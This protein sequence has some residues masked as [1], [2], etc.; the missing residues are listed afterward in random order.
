[1]MKHVVLA[2][3]LLMAAAQPSCAQPGAAG[4]IADLNAQ[5]KALS[6]TDPDK[7]LALAQQALARA[8]EAGDRRGEAEA[9]NYVAYGYR[10]QSLLDLARQNALESVRLYREAGDEW[11]QA[12]GYN[13]LG[14]IEAD[15]GKFP[16]ALE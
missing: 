3:L 2:A 14:L 1:M 16:E 11:G 9:L 8:R 5:A 13:T 4:P 15:A 12:Q 7:S 10:A 6:A